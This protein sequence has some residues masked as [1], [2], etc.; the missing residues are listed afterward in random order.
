MHDKATHEGEGL[1]SD[2]RKHLAKCT[3]IAHARKPSGN[4]G[5]EEGASNPALKC[6]WKHTMHI[7]CRPGTPQTRIPLRTAR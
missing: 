2:L 6:K 5:L 7:H 1:H 4:S 3:A